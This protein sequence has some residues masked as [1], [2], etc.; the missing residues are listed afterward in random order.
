MNSLLRDLLANIPVIPASASGTLTAGGAGDNTAV[1]GTSI[2]LLNYAY[3]EVIAFAIFG[4]AVL[5]ANQKLLVS[6][7][8][9]DSAD[10]STWTDVSLPNGSSIQSTLSSAVVAAAGGS[11]ATLQGVVTLQ[12]P[13]E[14]L[15]RYVRVVFTPDLDRAA[16]DT[17][18]VAAVAMLGGVKK[19]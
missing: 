12:C 3:P 10:G 9:Q 19:L 16:T 2:D 14:Y 15:R 17:A 6:A 8:I 5:G 7:K 18:T 1:N 13:T 11:G 4:N